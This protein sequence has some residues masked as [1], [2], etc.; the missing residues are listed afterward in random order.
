[1]MSHVL[2]ARLQIHIFSSN[3]LPDGDQPGT[4]LLTSEEG[5]GGWNTS[6]AMRTSHTSLEYPKDPP[7]P[8]T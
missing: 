1:M 7:P 6:L 2:Y 5:L 4:L 8:L 3:F